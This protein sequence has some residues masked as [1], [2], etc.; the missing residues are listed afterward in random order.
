MK[1]ISPI[2][3]LTIIIS[4]SAMFVLFGGCAATVQRVS[5][6][7]YEGDHVKADSITL[8]SADL[9][10]KTKTYTLPSAMKNISSNDIQFKEF[11]TYVEKVLSKKGYKRV[12]K[13][14]DLLVRLAFGVGS[15]KVEV[16]TRT[17][18]WRFPYKYSNYPLNNQEV[19]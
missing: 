6:T 1:P 4:I 10:S 2:S 8:P 3:I 13:D 19:C 9:K 7:T 15:P 5:Y 14:A 11:G 17:Y 18:N 12:N 16:S